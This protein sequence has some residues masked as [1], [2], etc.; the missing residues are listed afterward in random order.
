[1][2]LALRVVL[3]FGLLASDAIPVV[4][5]QTL[6]AADPASALSARLAQAAGNLGPD[7]IDNA[8]LAASQ[9]DALPNGYVPP[10]LVSLAAYGIPQRGGAYLRRIVIPDLQAMIEAARDDGVDLWVSSAYR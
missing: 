4:L 9:K 6:T 7:E 2:Y 5:S 3:L 8:L 1:M 10:D